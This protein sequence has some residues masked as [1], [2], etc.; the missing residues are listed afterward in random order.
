[1]DEDDDGNRDDNDSRNDIEAEEIPDS[2]IA[3]KEEENIVDVD[4]ERRNDEGNSLLKSSLISRRQQEGYVGDSDEPGDDDVEDDSSQSPDITGDGE[5]PEDSEG[6]ETTGLEEDD[7]EA[8]V[9]VVGR[10]RKA[11][12]ELHDPVRVRR[13]K[14]NAYYNTG[15]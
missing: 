14:L 3:N 6:I 8:N 9:K 4:L 5:V 15:R 2:M 7:E 1:M 10:R 13:R 12:G 11:L